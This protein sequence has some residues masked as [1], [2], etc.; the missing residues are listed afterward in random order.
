PLGFGRAGL[1]LHP[2]T[3]ILLS[4]GDPSTITAVIPRRLL[5][6][7]AFFVLQRVTSCYMS[8]GISRFQKVSLLKN[9]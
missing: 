6:A 9:A 2:R 8:G 5:L 7:G 3:A 1:F 4:D